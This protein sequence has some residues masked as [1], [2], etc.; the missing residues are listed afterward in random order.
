M[1]GQHEDNYTIDIT[2]G[3]EIFYPIP[4]SLSHHFS[5]SHKSE[6]STLTVAGALIFLIN[7][8][9]PWTKIFVTISGVCWC[10]SKC[11]ILFENIRKLNKGEETYI[12]FFLQLK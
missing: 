7:T 4:H 6:N 9:F 8:T 11:N 3:E 1:C 12:V 2:V 5:C 10:N